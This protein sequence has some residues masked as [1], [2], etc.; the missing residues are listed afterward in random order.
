V[1]NTSG[2][3][4]LSVE[5]GPFACGNT[6]TSSVACTGRSGHILLSQSGLS[7]PGPVTVRVTDSAGGT[8]TRT[9]RLG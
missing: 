7:S 6:S 9:L 5:N 4:G 3:G 2:T 1:S 8:T